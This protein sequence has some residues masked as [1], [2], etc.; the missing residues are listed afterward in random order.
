[1]AIFDRIGL[2]IT[3]EIPSLMLASRGHFESESSITNQM[4]SILRSESHQ[5]PDGLECD[6]LFVEILM[7][8]CKRRNA[9]CGLCSSLCTLR[10][11]LRKFSQI[12]SADPP[13]EFVV[14]SRAVL[15]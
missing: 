3:C 11:R 5:E 9:H 15:F 1:M 12:P 4:R 13:D 14:V 7:R 6:Q 10:A 2:N 8:L